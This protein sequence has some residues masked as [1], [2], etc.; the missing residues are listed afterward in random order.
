MPRKKGWRRNAEQRDKHASEERDR[1][2]KTHPVC[3][4]RGSLEERFASHVAPEAITGCWLWLGKPDK[5]GY[6]RINVG[7]RAG[8]AQFAHRVSWELHRGSIPNGMGVLHHCDTPSCVNPD[9]LF[10]GTQSDNMRDAR[11]KGRM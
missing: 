2:R 3:R 9:H 11:A 10:I 1:W 8:K 5:H 7:G 6:G 4:P